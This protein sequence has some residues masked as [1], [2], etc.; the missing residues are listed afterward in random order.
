MML[1]VGEAK[2]NLAEHVAGLR[3]LGLL[4]DEFALL[5][6]AALNIDHEYVFSFAALVAFLAGT[7]Q[8]D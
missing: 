1:A 4:D 6:F 7:N 5:S 2:V 3:L 8:V